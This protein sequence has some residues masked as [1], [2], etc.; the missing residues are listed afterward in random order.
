MNLQ[1]TW[2]RCWRYAI[3]LALLLLMTAP[4]IEQGDYAVDTARYAAVGLQMWRGGDFLTP[5]WHPEV[6]YLKKPPLALWINGLALHV[7]G[8]SPA[9]IRIT[10]IIGSAG[11]LL[12]A[13]GIA[14]LFFRRAVVVGT[15]CILALTLDFTRRTHGI[16]LDLWLT[17]FLLLAAL[18]ALSGMLRQRCWMIWLSGIPLGLSLLC[19]PL[20]GLLVV[21]MLLLFALRRPDRGRVVAGLLVATI[22]AIAVALPWHLM[23]YRL[24]GD[25]FIGV[26]F[27]GQVVDRAAGGIA[28]QPFWYYIT[29]LGQFYWPWI[30]TLA[31]AAVYFRRGRGLPS[32][33]QGMVFVWI[34]LAGWFIA[35]SIFPDKRPRYAI[36]LYPVAAIACAWALTLLPKPPLLRWYRRRLPGLASGSIALIV[37]LSLLPVQL[38]RPPRK[39]WNAL[40]NWIR[41]NGYSPAQIWEGRI[42]SNASSRFYLEFGWWP[43]PARLQGDAWDARGTQTVIRIHYDD[44]DT[45]PMPPDETVVFREGRM[46]ATRVEAYHP[47]ITYEPER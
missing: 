29:E 35:L 34:W 20:M 44:L 45:L 21:P 17:L 27:K 18:Q 2:R 32:A 47:E 41:E 6:V 12:A 16:C 36:P 10:G 15:G 11:C 38:Q 40:F 28:R 42:K 3:P 19:K 1:Q 43:L 22:I 24:H 30:I 26:Y 4:H 33:R 46:L 5:H 7:M 31:A 23:M 14:R 8:V 9:T 13:M 39:E 25:Q 37:V